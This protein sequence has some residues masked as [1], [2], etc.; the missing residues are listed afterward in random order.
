MAL[1]P[2]CIPTQRWLPSD[3]YQELLSINPE[4]LARATLY[5]LHRRCCNAVQCSAELDGRGFRMNHAC[6]FD[7]WP[8]AVQAIAISAGVL[9]VWQ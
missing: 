3:T 9:V 8:R 6:P 5:L 2:L 1:T 7:L 4:A